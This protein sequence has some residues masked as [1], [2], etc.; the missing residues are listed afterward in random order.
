VYRYRYV[1]VQ[2][3]DWAP[4]ERVAELTAQS[5]DLPTIEPGPFM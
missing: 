1:D 3:P 5:A 2:W 4:L